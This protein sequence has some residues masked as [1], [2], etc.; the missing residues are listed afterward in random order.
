MVQESATLKG[1]TIAITRPRGQA[2]E[3]AKMIEK[4]GGKSYFIPAIEIKGP[5]DLSPIKDFIGELQKGEVDYVVFMSVNG[6]RYLL[7][8]S[9]SLRRLDETLEGLKN[10]MIIAVGPRTAQELETHKIQ[11]NLVPPKY[12]SEGIVQSLKQ[13][14]VSGKT[15][16]IPR[17][18]GATPT[19]KEKLGEMGATVKEVY[20][21]KSI[22][23]VDQ[24]LKEK[25]FQD[26]TAE[27][28]DAIIF[29]SAL[30]VK[31]LFQM[32]NNQIS[33]KKLG[34]LMNSKLTVV[35]IG[36]VTADTLVEMGVR[37]D[38]MPDRHLFEEAIAALARYWN[39]V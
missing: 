5:N 35:A 27:K 2:D 22:L 36:P 9:E 26:L 1:K 23:P 29:G 13:L 39:S 25:F 18:S 38:V 28:I 34:G 24:I 19:L 6:V 4:K 33:P 15:I 20:I 37:V 10:T 31:N 3:V 12:T 16:Y 17:T 7:S 14:D 30:S 8:A 32:L 11:V 21:Y